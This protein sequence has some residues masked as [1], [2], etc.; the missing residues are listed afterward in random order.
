MAYPTFPI[1]QVTLAKLEKLPINRHPISQLFKVKDETGWGHYITETAQNGWSRE[2]G[3]AT[4]IAVHIIRFRCYNYFISGLKIY[5]HSN[6]SYG[7]AY[8]QSTLLS[9]KPTVLRIS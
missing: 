3:V 6:E 7:L 8:L 2:S 5:P 9:P 1:W 4:R